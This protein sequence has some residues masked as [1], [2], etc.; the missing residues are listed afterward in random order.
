MIPFHFCLFVAW[1]VVGCWLQGFDAASF[2]GIMEPTLIHV[3]AAVVRR[4]EWMEMT[5]CFGKILVIYYICVY[6]TRILKRR[7]LPTLALE[8]LS[9]DPLF[10]LFEPD[11]LAALRPDEAEKSERKG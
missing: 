1:Q 7:I 8:I 6:I 4:F 9:D 3:L 11:H 2:D 10:H 5:S